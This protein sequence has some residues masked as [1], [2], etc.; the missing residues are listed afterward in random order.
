MFG[1]YFDG[2]GFMIPLA[3]NSSDY[4]GLFGGAGYFGTNKNNAIIKN[5][6]VCG[7]AVGTLA[8]GG[9]VA[10]STIS[11]AYTLQIINCVNLAK[12]STTGSGTV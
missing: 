8:T 5:V 9:I 12:I 1:G 4:A 10:E 2:Q 11:F 7:Y 6:V 3:I